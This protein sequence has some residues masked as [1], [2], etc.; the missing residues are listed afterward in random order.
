MGVSLEEARAWLRLGAG[1]EDALVERLIGA[2]V[3][4]CETFTGQ[5]LIVRAAEEVVPLRAGVARPAAR[6]VVAIESVALVAEGGV[7]TPLDPGGYR[8]DIV[9]GR[10]QVTVP[11]AGDGQ[12]RIAVRAGLA[13]AADDLPGAIRHGLERMVQHLY[14]ARDDRERPPPAAIA[15]LWQPWRRLALGRER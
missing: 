4:I 11:G 7:E 1:T 2:A 12:V 14:E 5:R 10:A 13:E 3:N 9:A 6:P 15:A 8:V